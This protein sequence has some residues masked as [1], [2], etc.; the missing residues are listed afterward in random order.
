M[1]YREILSRAK[2]A[3][4]CKDYLEI[5]KKYKS[6]NDALRDP[7][8]PYMAC[9]YADNVIGGRWPEAE[10]LIMKEA[11]YAY[12]YAIHIIR[13]QWIEAEPVIRKYAEYWNRYKMHFKVN[14]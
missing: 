3:G 6:L 14:K 1:R 8:A 4:A 11:G 13:G 5:A 10:P 2:K 9:W 12:L 7:D